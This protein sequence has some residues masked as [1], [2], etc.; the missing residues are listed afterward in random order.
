MTRPGWMRSSLVT[1]AAGIGAILLPLLAPAAARAIDLLDEK[2]QIHGY[3][4]AQVRGIS[5]NFTEEFDLTQWYNVLNVEIDLDIL[6]RRLR[7][8]GFDYRLRA[9]RGPL[10]LRVDARLRPLGQHRRVRQPR[11]Q[12]ARTSVAGREC[13]PVGSDQ[14]RD[15]HASV[16]LGSS[17]RPCSSTR[18]RLPPPAGSALPARTEI[19]RGFNQLPSIDT[20]YGVRQVVNG[21]EY[22]P[23]FY[24]F[25][26]YRNYGFALRAIRG[27]ENRRDTQAMPW[28]PKD[29]I[30][31]QGTLADRVNPFRV[32]DINPITGL[33]GGNAL[34]YRP[35]PLFGPNQGPS[36]QAQGIF[37]PSAPYA[38]YLRD[39][40]SGRFQQNFSQSELS[41][42]RGASQ[43]Q[44]KELKEAYLDINMF[45]GSLFLRLGKQTIV[46][47]KTELFATTDQFNPN[48][49]ALASLPALEESRIPVWAARAI[50]SF[51]EV[52]PLSDVRLE[53]ALDLDTFYPADLG[54]CGEA[55][56]PNP[57]CNKTFGLLGHGIAHLGI[58]GEDRPPDWWI[59]RQ[60]AAGRRPARVP[61]GAVQLRAGGLL[62][63]RE[64]PVS[65]AAHELLAQRRSDVRPAAEDRRHG[66]LRGRERAGLPPARDRRAAELGPQPA[67]L[68]L[69]LLGERGLLAGTRPE[70]LRAVG[71]QQRAARLRRRPDRRDHR[72]GPGGKSRRAYASSSSR[73][74][75][76]R[77]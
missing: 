11:A 25:Q 44:T 68:H 26:R 75:P 24:T 21:V 31:P 2:I 32:Q 64:D 74:S 49:L 50:Y 38:R 71:L 7:R 16:N 60:G 20:L 66:G 29:D 77:L 40:G 61:L 42:N 28:D 9:R 67:V 76:T 15:A 47:G 72:H 23:A 55:Y 52:G 36:D 22:L 73:A 45:E 62:E 27:N 1:S 8:P 53:V 58:A 39:G 37:Y 33:R 14:L 59:E 17:S 56:T 6:A 46:W 30:D 54:R 18:A 48:D 51:Y 19:F 57:V 10:R 4:E 12:A 70:R 41:W 34:P 63:L 13:E 43:Q 5:S 69:R 65:G 35:A 3:F